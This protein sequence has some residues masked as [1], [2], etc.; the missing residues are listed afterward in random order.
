MEGYEAL[1]AKRTGLCDY[2]RV[3]VI[4]VNNLTVPAKISP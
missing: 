1:I 4:F 2:H 3:A